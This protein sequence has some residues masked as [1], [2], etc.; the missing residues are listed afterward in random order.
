[1]TPGESCGYCWPHGNAASCSLAN[2]SIISLGSSCKNSRKTPLVQPKRS[3][4]LDTLRSHAPPTSA[5]PRHTFPGWCLLVGNSPPQW[6]KTCTQFG[7]RRQRSHNGA[8]LRPPAIEEGPTSLTGNTMSAASTASLSVGRY[9]RRV[10]PSCV[11][12][13]NEPSFLLARM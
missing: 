13:P 10:E 11:I 9:H 3:H 7:P 12:S 6:K 2:R 5:S 1:M 8:G 4:W